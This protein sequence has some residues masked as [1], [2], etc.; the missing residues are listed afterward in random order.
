MRIVREQP[1][2]LYG[3]VLIDVLLLEDELEM[4]V[5]LAQD[6]RGALQLCGQHH[7]Q[8]SKWIQSLVNRDIP[9]LAWF[10]PF[11]EE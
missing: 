11:Q 7:R 1:R 5:Q 8:E 10:I 3:T 6:G 9:S 2:S 4:D